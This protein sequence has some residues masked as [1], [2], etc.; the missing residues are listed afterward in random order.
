MGHREIVTAMAITRR[1]PDGTIKV[2]NSPRRPKDS[3]EETHR[4]VLKQTGYWGH[5]GAGCLVLSRKTGR[6]LFNLRS[7]EVLEPHTYGTWG[8]A[9]DDG[10]SRI[11]AVLRELRE[12]A[13]Y[14]GPVKLYKM[15]VFTAPGGTF[16]YTNYIAVVDAEF[17]PTLDH[18]SDGFKW[19]AF[20]K[21]PTPLHRGA[22]YL[23][24]ESAREIKALIDQHKKKA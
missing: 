18:E 4:S 13:G 3:Q 12:E 20:G 9:V 14:H 7:A 21:W 8:G 17:D 19:V 5:R 1:M 16:S 15:A 22:K 11:Q 6:L 24:K 23:L 10:E 2:N